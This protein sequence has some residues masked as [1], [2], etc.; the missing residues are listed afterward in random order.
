MGRRLSELKVLVSKEDFYPQQTYD[1]ATEPRNYAKPAAIAGV[2][3]MGFGGLALNNARLLPQRTKVRAD[4]E[5]TKAG[6]AGAKAR[7]ATSAGDKARVSAEGM[8]RVNPLKVTRMRE[9][10]KLTEAAA[11]AR[12]AS[13]TQNQVSAASTRALS[14]VKARRRTM[15]RTGLAAAGVGLGLTALA[16]RNSKQRRDAG[17]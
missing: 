14:T 7:A 17:Y 8:K 11:E 15:T 12:R 1:Y 5:R 16:A 9:A 3:A 10:K 2:G 13:A 6:E 4:R